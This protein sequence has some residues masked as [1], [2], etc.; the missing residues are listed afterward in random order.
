L[1]PEWEG[2]LRARIGETGTDSV[3]KRS[4]SVLCLAAA[5]ERDVKDPFLDRDG[6]RTL[7]EDGLTYLRDE[8]DLRGFD[9]KKGWMH[10]TAH[11]ADLLAALAENRFFTKRDEQRVLA[12]ISQRLASANVIFS[13][14]EQDRLADVAANIVGQRD[15][16]LELWGSWLANMDNDDQAVFAEGPPTVPALL[17]FENDTYFLQATYVEISIRPAATGSTDAEKAVLAVLRRRSPM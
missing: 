17:R 4:F 13:Y 1:L 10:A 15:F 8:Q 9:A 12:A 6:F 3:F 16:D 5:A 7:L 11:T 14:G 2:N